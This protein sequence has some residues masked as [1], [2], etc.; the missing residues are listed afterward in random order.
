MQ[1][2]RYS[3]KNFKTELQNKPKTTL[4]VLE[5]PA[6]LSYEEFGGLSN[7]GLQDCVYNVV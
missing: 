2:R 5:K 6:V 4:K 1:P 3:K 7:L